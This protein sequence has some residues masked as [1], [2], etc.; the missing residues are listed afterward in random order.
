MKG[1]FGRGCL[2]IFP[3]FKDSVYRFCGPDSPESTHRY[4]EKLFGGDGE[5]II[6]WPGIAVY[7]GR[8]A[9]IIFPLGVDG[10]RCQR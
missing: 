6:C 10:P 5:S 2:F 1:S 9:R 4:L 8:A 7:A 3:E